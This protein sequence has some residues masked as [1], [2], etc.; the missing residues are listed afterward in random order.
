MK[1]RAVTLKKVLFDFIKGSKKDQEEIKK[2]KKV[3]TNIIIK[4]GR[5]HLSPFKYEDS[6][7]YIMADGPDWATY[8]RMEAGNIK[9]TIVREL[10]IKVDKVVVRIKFFKDF[11]VKSNK[12]LSPLKQLGDKDINK[13]KNS[14]KKDDLFGYL[15]YEFYKKNR[16][17]N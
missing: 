16:G 10:K 3:W 2:I 9:E 11:T 14:I 15:L 7:L 12:K 4:D 5:V 13:C 1:K 8:V 6:I 17:E